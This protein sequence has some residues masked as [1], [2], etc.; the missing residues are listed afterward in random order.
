MN[1]IDSPFHTLNPLTDG[2]AQVKNE[3][4][5]M[6]LPDGVPAEIASLITK[7]I[8]AENPNDRPGMPDLAHQLELI[9][10]LPRPPA[11]NTATQALPVGPGTTTRASK[12]KKKK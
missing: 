2:C 10:R 3:N 5:R 11:A 12:K 1:N 9:T 6:T 7:K 8:W 4:Y